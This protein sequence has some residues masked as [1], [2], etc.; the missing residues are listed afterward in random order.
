[1]SEA[2]KAKDPR[3][4]DVGDLLT[5]FGDLMR[6]SGAATTALKLQYLSGAYHAKIGGFRATG[7]TLIS[8]LIALKSEVR[9]ALA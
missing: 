7:D 8:A 2:T 3:Q 1:M 5:W 9:G 4:I 6:T